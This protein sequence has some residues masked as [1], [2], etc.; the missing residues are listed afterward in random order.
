[1]AADWNS[2]GKTMQ[3]ASIKM[4]TKT[5]WLQQKGRPRHECQKVKKRHRLKKQRKK[6]RTIQVSTKEWHK[7]LKTT[8][9]EILRLHM[10]TEI[11]RKSKEV[12]GKTNNPQQQSKSTEETQ[13]RKQGHSGNPST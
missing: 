11:R 12:K 13:C 4:Q 3:K 2:C 6:H 5:E 1:M 8:I 9:Y 7:T 10:N